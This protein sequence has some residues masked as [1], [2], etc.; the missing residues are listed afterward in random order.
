LESY[1]D[2]LGLPQI[3]V[4]R[5]PEEQASGNSPN[6]DRNAERCGYEEDAVLHGGRTCAVRER[7]AGGGLRERW[8]FFL[9]G[10]IELCVHP[11]SAAHVA[12]F[13]E[14]DVFKFDHRG[15]L[16]HSV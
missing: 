4:C 3:L 14:R 13:V 16:G 11:W 10:V 2:L 1:G 5:S 9:E 15:L 6:G 8:D 7:H 12:S